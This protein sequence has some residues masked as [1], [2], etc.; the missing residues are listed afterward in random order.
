M[1]KIVIFE[2]QKK[3]AE[4]ILF[5]SSILCSIKEMFPNS[6]IKI[7]A[8]RKHI[9]FL[10]EKCKVN[11]FCI[12]N[13]P[14]AL[15][16]SRKL[17]YHYILL[18]QII[19]EFITLVNIRKENAEALVCLS[20]D[21][22]V[23]L[24]AKMVLPKKRKVFFFHEIL[25][26]LENHYTV[27]NYN[28]WL[29]PALQLQ[30]IY[31]INIVLGENI[32][33]NLKSLIPSVQ[34][35]WIDHPCE[36]FDNNDLSMVASTMPIKIGCIGFGTKNKGSHLIFELEEKLHARSYNIEMHYIGRLNSNII[37]P[38]NTNVKI[39][40]REKAVQIAPKEYHCLVEG[41]TYCIFF[42]PSDS[43]RLYASGAI[44]DALAHSKPII[45]FKNNYFEYV[46]KKMGNIGYLCNSID[47]MNEIII[48]IIN[49]NDIEMRK[50]YKEQ[51]RNI[52][53]GVKY[54]SEVIEEKLKQLLW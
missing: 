52:R 33:D 15:T 46:F 12:I 43:Y 24:F 51:Q 34:F 42:Y 16:V 4:H 17:L 40:A 50:I 48:C 13:P 20:V 47:D 1:Q 26:Y 10:Q 25:Q 9:D 8:E 37:I 5:N 22:F 49:S 18:K 28:Y 3:G 38:N 44:F 11:D 41:M 30:N 39:Y 19:F 32:R 27:L 36:Y 54:F 35:D 21:P 29:R 53:Q 7:Y 31:S 6:N 23:V 45:A 14:I 2:P